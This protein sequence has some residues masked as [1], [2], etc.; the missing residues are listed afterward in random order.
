MTKIK[1]FIPGALTAEN[2]L[3]EFIKYSRETLWCINEEG[4]W[5]DNYWYIRG[6]NGTR[7]NFYKGIGIGQRNQLLR[8]KQIYGNV[9]LELSKALINYGVIISGWKPS[10]TEL[11]SSA[12]RFLEYHLKKRPVIKE[13]INKLNADDIDF[14]TVKA[15]KH[16]SGGGLEQFS[17]AMKRIFVILHDC[18]LISSAIRWPEERFNVPDERDKIGADGLNDIRSKMADL[19]DILNLAHIFWKI[20]QPNNPGLVGNDPTRSYSDVDEFVTNVFAFLCSSPNR[21]GEVISLTVD[22]LVE[23]ITSGGEKVILLKTFCQKKRKFIE[24]PIYDCMYKPLHKALQ[25]AIK[26]SEHARWLAAWLEDR[27]HE[28]PRHPNCPDVG[29]DDELSPYQYCLAMG[30]KPVVVV[31]CKSHSIPKK[32]KPRCTLRKLNKYIHQNKPRAFPY[33]AG[34]IDV[35]IRHCIFARLKYQNGC[36]QNSSPVILA[37][38]GQSFGSAWSGNINNQGSRR[39]KKGKSYTYFPYPIETIWKRFG[40]ERRDGAEPNMNTHSIRH[41]LDNINAMSGM[42]Q[43]E[44]AFVAGRDDIN[45]NNV[46]DHRDDEYFLERAKQLKMDEVTKYDSVTENIMHRIS[47]QL[48]VTLEEAEI[49]IEHSDDTPW[50]HC[51]RVV[52]SLPCMTLDCMNC[53]N[54]FSIKGGCPKKEEN[55]DELIEIKEKELMTAYKKGVPEENWQVQHTAKQLLNAIKLKFLQLSVEIPNRTLLQVPLE[56]T[57]PVARATKHLDGSSTKNLKGIKKLS[58]KETLNQSPTEKKLLKRSRK[59]RRGTEK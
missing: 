3:T 21:I 18:N 49:A 24:K 34:N 30:L 44:R 38:P 5:E 12:L 13:G 33:V 27:P 8:G 43:I 28:F 35:P 22:C 11:V 32:F 48:P 20:G 9:F 40:I 47:R 41:F 56:D 58:Y 53:T 19:E 10:F 42:S 39:V 52:Q 15:L 4:D 1:E 37:G 46:Y 23:D 59:R 6:M 57:S 29:E 50:G 36:Y 54:H 25:R 2:N 7:I 17:R 55:L 26:A 16:Y 14:L 51:S 45:H 31:N